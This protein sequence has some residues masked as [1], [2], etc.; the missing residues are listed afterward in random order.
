MIGSL[1]SNVPA[2]PL[3]AQLE[4]A[5]L[6]DEQKK[7]FEKNVADMATRRPSGGGGRPPLR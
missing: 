5:N 6:T 2:G 1:E 7:V 4:K 3:A